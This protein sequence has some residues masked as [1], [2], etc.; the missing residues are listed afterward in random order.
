[1]TKEE[2]RERIAATEKGK[3]RTR[4]APALVRAVVVHASARAAAGESLTKVAGELGLE[5]GTLQ[6]WCARWRKGA[7]QPGGAVSVSDALTF[8][9]LDA[10]APAAATREGSAVE[11]ALPGGV[12]VRVPVGFDGPTLSRVLSV[13]KGA[14]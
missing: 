13:M 2:L 1:M 10:V 7:M 12:S 5:A 8:V 11:I 9:R 6:R 4:Y 3:E 14:A